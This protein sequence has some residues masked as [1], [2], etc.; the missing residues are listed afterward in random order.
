MRVHQEETT[1]WQIRHTDTLRVLPPVCPGSPVTA[2]R[3]GR[4]A[5]QNLR[6]PIMLATLVVSWLTVGAM[7]ELAM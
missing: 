4:G 2:R 6:L 5:A 7:D 3:S 1:G